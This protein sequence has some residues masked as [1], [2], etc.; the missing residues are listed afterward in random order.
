MLVV[1]EARCLPASSTD[2]KGRVHVVVE[3]KDPPNYVKLGQDAVDV[4]SEWQTLVVPFPASADSKPGMTHASLMLGGKQ[5][6]LEISNMR[7]L[8]YGA[9]FD[10]TKLPRPFISYPGREANAPWRKEALARIEKIRTTEIAVE[11][12]DATGKPQPQ[13]QVS[14]ALKRQS[15]GF[16][17]AVKAKYLM[18]TDETSARYR[19]LV[20]EN[21]SAIVLENDLKPFAWTNGAS[22]DRKD[23]RQEWT[24]GEA[25][26]TPMA[27]YLATQGKSVATDKEEAR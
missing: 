11:V 16:G 8:N 4:T 26:T 22:N 23:Y 14:I 2:G 5:Q 13:A 3:L 18:G 19:T 21:F 25:G 10:L 24:L 12:V 27:E 15:F 7:L 6:A 17:T 1:F 9:A 20:E